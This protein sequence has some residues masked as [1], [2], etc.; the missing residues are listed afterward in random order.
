MWGE[1]FNFVGAV[2]DKIF[3]DK[4]ARDKAKLEMIRLEQEGQFKEIEKRYTAIVTEAQS[5][6]KWTSRAR[7]SFMYVFYILLLMGLPMG[8]IFSIN[9]R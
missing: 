6:D 3:P 8:I 9:Q 4:D 1:A 2:I 7:P 5:S